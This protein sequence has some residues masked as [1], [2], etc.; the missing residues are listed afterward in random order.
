[1]LGQPIAIF[2]NQVAPLL[3]RHALDLLRPTLR[4]IGQAAVRAGLRADTLT[5]CAFA[6]GMSACVAIALGHF[7]WAL[8]LMLLGRLADG[9]DGTVARL[10]QPTDRGAYLDIVLDFIFYAGVPLAFAVQSPADHALPAATLLAAFLG[11]G[12]SFLAFASV[13]AKRGMT[14]MTY[15][16]KGLYF[17]GGLTE[18]TETIVCF[19]L[20]CLLP[21]YFGVLAYVFAAMCAVTTVT[22][23]AAGASLLKEDVR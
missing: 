19:V 18:G 4:S 23:I 11:T 7:V 16:D 20:M 21:A 17:L 2:V 22:R 8:V 14:S 6:L 1:M 12:A 3:D 5:W 9:L 13:A 10:T 15:P